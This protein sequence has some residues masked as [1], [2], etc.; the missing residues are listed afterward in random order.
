MKRQLVLIPCLIS[1]LAIVLA[2]GCTDNDETMPAP[3]VGSVDVA[4]GE[5]TLELTGITFPDSVS[6]SVTV[7]VH[8]T[9]NAPMVGT[10][11]RVSLSSTWYDTL[12]YADPARGDTTD[13]NGRAEYV[14][15]AH[16]VQDTW[17][18]AGAGGASDS[19]HIVVLPY[20][21]GPIGVDVRTDPDTLW[22]LPQ[23][24]DSVRLLVRLQYDWGWASPPDTVFLSVSSGYVTPYVV[25]DDPYWE[26]EGWWRLTGNYGT[27]RLIA[28]A[29]AEHCILTDTV[30]VSVLPSPVGQVQIVATDTLY[31]VP[32]DTASTPVHVYVA[33]VEGHALPGRV[34][35]ISLENP[36]IGFLQPVNPQLG[37]TTDAYGRAQ[38][39]YT[40]TQTGQN[41]IL[42]ICE[43][44]QAPPHPIVTLY[45]P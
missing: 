26:A 14:Y 42:A 36:Q 29:P 32:G 1:V 30:W 18:R 38:Y 5:Y 35:H 8:N 19:A 15:L 45:H 23:E 2:V 11:V 31:L 16:G 41:V 17:I 37:D 44:I 28:H 33:G 43:G 24:E 22:L 27:F 34:V 10:I 40:T 12:L 7:T 21:E 4:L 39:M 25:I 3:A 9:Q 6:T 20:N 13:E